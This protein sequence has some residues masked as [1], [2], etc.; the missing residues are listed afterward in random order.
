MGST[1]MLRHWK[2]FCAEKV[3]K[4]TCS[5]GEQVKRK[6]DFANKGVVSSVRQFPVSQ[7]FSRHH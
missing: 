7:F 3:K 5:F 2:V 6:F 4:Q 1:G